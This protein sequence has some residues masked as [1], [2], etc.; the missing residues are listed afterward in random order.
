MIVCVCHRV[1]DREIARQ[2]HAG[3]SFEDIQFSLGVGTQCG[4][5]E[6][7]ARD[8]VST[9]AA[10]RPSVAVQ[11]VGDIARHLYRPATSGLA[12]ANF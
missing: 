11:L 12:A 3:S 6:S 1:S 9:C 4:Q 2:A 8:I 10:A 7:C 5:C